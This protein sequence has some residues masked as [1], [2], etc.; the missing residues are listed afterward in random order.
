MAGRRT[1]RSE[2]AEARATAADEAVQEQGDGTI[3]PPRT[4]TTYVQAVHPDTGL[5]VTFVPGEALPEWVRG[6]Q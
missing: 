1:A 3:R 6:E 2:A 5:A 4:A